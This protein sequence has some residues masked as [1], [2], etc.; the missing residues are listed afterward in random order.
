MPLDYSEYPKAWK[1]EIRPAIMKRAGEV[2]N[3]EGLIIQEAHCEECNVLNHA[4]GARNFKG[5]W[6]DESHIEGLGSDSGE[7]HFQHIKGF[8]TITTIVLT[9]AHLDHDKTNHDVKLDRL[10]AWCQRC[11]LNYDRPRHIE[12]RK[13]NLKKKKGIIDM[14]TENKADGLH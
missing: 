3:E 10:R 2:R 8:P 7:W 1:T 13:N 4:K 5:E 9:V 14:F 11:H 6:L 12:N